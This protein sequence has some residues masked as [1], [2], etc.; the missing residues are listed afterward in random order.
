MAS[1]TTQLQAINKMLRT[2]G[3]AP[4][5]ALPSTLSDAPR[6]ATAAEALLEDTLK[7]ILIHG[8]DFNTETDVPLTPG[9]DKKVLI[10]SNW[11]WVR[12]HPGRHESDRI[13]HRYDRNT[14]QPLLYDTIDRT[15]E[16]T[17]DVYVDY[18]F[19]MPYDAIPEVARKAILVRAAR[20]FADELGEG[21]STFEARDETLAFAALRRAH[22][23][24]THRSLLDNFS[25]VRPVQR[26]YV[27][28]G[29]R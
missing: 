9:A 29:I 16:F 7:E 5:T 12:G 15:F 4:V 8:W 22:A 17:A 23:N 21:A 1:T 13:S 25:A 24:N 6:D 19:Y 18:A 10:D 3:L 26:H 27:L 28:R 2:V 14:K 11:L 20:I